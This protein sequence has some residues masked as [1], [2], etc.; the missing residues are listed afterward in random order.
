M[1]F[2]HSWPAQNGSSSST[3]AIRASASSRVR[4]IHITS[5]VKLQAMPNTIIPG[6][7]GRRD[8]GFRRRMRGAAPRPTRPERPRPRHRRRARATL[9][10]HARR[11]VR[12][13]EGAR[14][15]IA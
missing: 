15:E 10:P 12:A 5:R 4:Q 14:L 1:R 11:G 6:E 13:A 3:A 8:S 2:T 7:I 9:F